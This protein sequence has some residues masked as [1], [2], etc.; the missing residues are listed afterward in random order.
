MSRAVTKHLFVAS[1]VFPEATE[2]FFVASELSHE[3]SENIF[4]MAGEPLLAPNN[5]AT[6]TG[7]FASSARRADMEEPGAER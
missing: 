4:V 1:K 3:A 7:R 6:H 5:P 2:K